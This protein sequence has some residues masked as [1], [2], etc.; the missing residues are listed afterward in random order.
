MFSNFHFSKGKVF[1]LVIVFLL[2]AIVSGVT[3][4]QTINYFNNPTQYQEK[5][6]NIQDRIE[7]LTK[8]ITEISQKT[9]ITIEQDLS[10]NGD[11]GKQTTKV[12]VIHDI[13]GDQ[14]TNPTN[15]SNGVFS[16]LTLTSLSNDSASTQSAQKVLTVN[17]SGT[18]ELADNNLNII[19]PSALGGNPL[20]FDSELWKA[21]SDLF[22][23][24]GEI[25]IGKS[26]GV[27]LDVDGKAAIEGKLTIHSDWEDNLIE[28]FPN[29][30]SGYL[31]SSGGALYINNSNNPGSGIGIYSNAGD[32]ALG[33]MINVKV[34]N[35]LYGQAAF[36]M[37]YDGTSNAV[38][39]VANTDDAS[40]NALS[41]TNNNKLDSA[42]GVIGYESSKGTI[43]VSHRKS[44]DDSNAS[45]ISVDLQGDGTAAQGIY[46]DST[47]IGGTTGKLLRLR[48]ETVDRFVVDKNGSLTIGAN[49]Y[50]TSITKTG[51]VSGDEF[52]VGT[53]GAFRVQRSDSNSEAFRVQIS[54]DT[55][56]RW[57]GTSDG[58]LKWGD[59][60]S[61][62]DVVL[63]RSAASKLLLNGASLDIKS[64]AVNTD[65]LTIT[66][67]DNSRLGRFVE[68]S[69]GHGWFEVDNNTGTAQVLFRADGG[70]HYFRTGEVGI[71][72]TGPNYQLDVFDDAAS[73]YVANFA[74]DGNNENRYG[75]R[76]QAGADD[77]SGTTY[78][79]DAYDGDGDQVG[80]LA[81][82]AGTF[83]VTD[84]SDIR[85]KTNIQD[86]TVDGT[87]LI[88]SLRVVDFNRLSHP[89]DPLIHG[90]IAQEVEQVFPEMVT[91]GPDGLLGIQKSTLIPIITKAI[92][93]QNHDIE[94]IKE[95]LNPLDSVLKIGK[96]LFGVVSELFVKV[97]TIFTEIV[98]FE[99]DIVVNK[100]VAGV[101]TIIAG[102]KSIEVT[103][104]NPLPGTPIIQ[105]TPRT[106]VDGNYHVEQK[107]NQSFEIHLD[108]TQNR[109]VEFN[110]FVVNLQ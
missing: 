51:N 12:S 76:V 46:V 96:S 69:G 63:E 99:K 55:Q 28:L 107:S 104:E 93:E 1:V 15:N 61:A 87:A 2:S 91:T 67:S 8:S 75:L 71:G 85:T 38:E 37:N 97:K 82:S 60:S 31:S 26:P 6:A 100:N 73:S 5:L 13:S 80:Y 53:N 11:A 83:A 78:Y 58:K 68:T 98:V 36:Y 47:A 84:L 64:S 90:F 39:I 30:N 57:L 33:N 88:N 102:N 74:N 45:G 106:S 66:A 43:K 21:A 10:E 105:L 92:Q 109:T 52:F 9:G 79:L 50:D 59:G 42:L 94:K 110:W 41:I 3:A 7:S 22:F 18:V 23:N 34:D 44:G 108:Q 16:T 24:S 56:G 89:D 54:G 86:T 103:L 62:Q 25:G 32:E 14:L 17:Q 77:G 72:L 40:S 4:Y 19:A 65:V 81:N 101:A 29:G 35:E 48:N 70:D 27:P 95:S 20:Y 49:G